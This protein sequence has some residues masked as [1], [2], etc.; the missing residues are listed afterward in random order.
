MRSLVG[1]L[2]VALTAPAWAEDPPEEP[3]PVEDPVV[4]VEEAPGE[5]PVEEGTPPVAPL[6]VN[7][8]PDATIIEKQPPPKEPY[9]RGG[10]LLGLGA[11]L[12]SVPDEGDRLT[13]G[14]IEI[15]AV[16]ILRLS[17]V[18]GLEY[19]ANM[20]IHDFETM[21]SIGE[22]A[23]KPV[24]GG[25][26]GVAA[27]ILKYI[28]LTPAALV[29]SPIVS[30]NYGVGFG[31]IAFTSPK[32]P[33]VYFDVGVQSGLFLRLSDG[34][35]GAGVGYYAGLGAELAPRTTISLRF[36]HSLTGKDG[37]QAYAFG[38][39]VGFSASRKGR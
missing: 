30:S 21:G 15:E 33:A 34:S 12:V 14:G 26:G 39:V 4:P 38:L 28:F 27:S 23:F 29:L 25:D 31:A 20:L 24:S 10:R 19:M 1:L 32:T 36:L 17:D 13:Y 11:G 16:G 5:L 22:W 2:A 8:P 35:A 7:T 3:A 6:A 37:D 9:R 18:F